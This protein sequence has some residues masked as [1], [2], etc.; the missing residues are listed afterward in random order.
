MNDAATKDRVDRAALRK[1]PLSWMA[2]NPVAANLLMIALLA[3]GFI[4]AQNVR[5]EVMP[6]QELDVVTVTV[7]YPGASPEE[8]ERSII[9]AIEENVNSLAGVAEV[10][11]HAFESY[12]TVQIELKTGTD[13]NKA[14]TDVKN[15]VDRIATFPEEAERPLVSLTERTLFAM[16]IVLHG[17]VDEKTMQTLGE[18]SRD[19]LLAKED[20]TRVELWGARPYEIGIEIP[21]AELR[22]YGLTLPTVATRVRAVAFD[23]PAGGVKTASGE[24]LLRAT[25]RRD[26][27]AEFADIPLLEGTD[28]NTLTVGDVAT[29]EDG[30]S[31]IDMYP[32]FNGERA[33]ILSVY[34]VDEQSPTTVA[35]AGRAYVED[36]EK[37]L[38]EGV[39]VRTIADLSQD[40]EAR[41]DLLLRNAGFGL[42]LVLVVLGLFLEP[43]L[44]FWVTLGIPVSF[45]GAFIVLPAVGV[46]LNM[47]SMFAF[48]VTLG[49]VVDD[50]IVIGE[51]IHRWRKAGLSPTDAAIKGVKEMATPV[52]FSVATTVAAFAPLAGVPGTAGKLFMAIPVVVIAVLVMSLI[53]SFFILPAHLAHSREETGHGPFGWLLRIQRRFSDGVERF[54]RKVY[55]PFVGKTLRHRA[56]TIAV[57][58]AALVASAGLVTGG[59]VKFIDFPEDESDIIRAV[60]QLP[61]GASIEES[62][63]V[64][65]RMLEAANE[66]VAE[67]DAEQGREESI[68]RGMFA[69]LGTENGSHEVEAHLHLAPVE[70]QG[71]TPST[72]VQQRW[73]EKIG[74]IS[75]LESLVFSTSMRPGAS[76]A[77]ISLRV[78]HSD[79]ATLEA[80]ARD[81]ATALSEVDG[82]RDVDDGILVGK[83]QRDFTLSAAGKAEGFTTAN[84]AG[85]VRAAFYGAEALRQQRGRYEVKVM[86][87]LPEEERRA[88][89]TVEDLV[90][91][92]PSG[93]EMALRD[94]ADVSYGRAYSRIDRIDARRALN[95]TAW[96]QGDTANAGEV[97]GMMLTKVVPELQKKYPGLLADRAGRQRHMAE[98]FDYL[99]SAYVIAI[100]L[101]FLL[102]A[103]PLR[104]YAQPIFVVMTAIPFG[105]VGAVLAHFAFGLDLSIVSLM[106]MVALS[107]VIVN[108][109]LVYV[110]AANRLRAEGAS[111]FDAARQAAE[112]RFRA[113]ILTSL[114]TFFGLM[115]MIFETSQTA[116]MIIP[117]AIALG[118]GILFSTLVVLVL[119]P[120][121]FLTLERLRERKARSRS[122]ELVRKLAAG[123]ATAVLLLGATTTAFAQPASAAPKA[124]QGLTL[125]AALRHAQERNITLDR[126]QTDIDAAAAR[127]AQTWSV[128]LPTVSAGATWTHLDHADETTVSGVKMTTRR[129]DD[130]SAAIQVAVPLVQADAWLGVRSAKASERVTLLSVEQQ[131][132]QLLLY[133]GQAWFQARSA[134]TL[135]SQLE[136]QLEAAQ[137][138]AEVASLRHR[139][140]VGQR[141]DVVRAEQDVLSLRQQLVAAQ[142]GSE[143]ARDALGVLTGLGGYPTPTGEATLAPPG[144][145]QLD[146]GVGAREDVRLMQAQLTLAERELERSLMAFVPSIGAS[147]QFDWQITDPAGF[148]STDDTRWTTFV[149]LSI[150][151]FDWTRHATLDEKRADICRARFQVAETERDAR[152]ELRSCARDRDS[153]LTR[154][155]LSAAQLELAREALAIAEQDYAAGT[156]SSLSVTEARGSRVTAELD[157][158][159]IDLEAELATLQLLRALG[160]DLTRL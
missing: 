64:L 16:L 145:E 96:L 138:Y 68:G 87:R 62:R 110:D 32:T 7:A 28:G 80:A 143:A 72:V 4:M 24:V 114:T 158:I 122:G 74:A 101:V 33:L 100:I 18:Q 128:L 44:A 14:L 25:E 102:I 109:S 157:L 41:L 47:I 119:V 67:I 121:L 134:G 77:P 83:P 17:D 40:Y 51:N 9:L 34:S 99:K 116:Q 43:K 8:V 13:R 141:I 86:V 88:L 38:P 50:A 19:E 59:H 29:I 23:Q 129:Q 151:L 75:G 78:S 126:L 57:A 35:Q 153:A 125:Q 123:A 61:Y 150:P 42:V 52:F 133:V 152:Q 53:E 106:G 104:S 103:V 66:T 140:G 155:G 139:S 5:Q 127:L 20:I 136:A 21:E 85:Q 89:A 95:V 79:P 55:G 108:D 45:L 10:R 147:W 12:G 63:V 39:G 36:L 97:T 91:R 142:A 81:L 58:V 94:A 137:R 120:S 124:D 156:G 154:R 60:A 26:T 11:S 48:I 30:Y 6:S 46:S 144:E 112:G 70:E 132:Q 117:M 15:A 130:L 146:D 27:G 93:G 113:I 69:L 65:D 31:D 3:S 118:F 73:R 160:E 71:A 92:S 111:A 90:V 1:G 115:P 159:S 107:G 56:V 149:T 131:R 98:F 76:G 2:R 105:M 82:V 37:R 54:I 49:I 84:L 22:R 148:G 135:V